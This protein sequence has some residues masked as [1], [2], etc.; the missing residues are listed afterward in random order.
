M[1]VIK[2]STVPNMLNAKIFEALINK[3]DVLVDNFR[4]ENRNIK[5]FVQTN[6]FF[7]YKLFI[8]WYY[9]G[10]WIVWIFLCAQSN[11]DDSYRRANVTVSMNQTVI[12][13]YIFIRYNHQFNSSNHN[14]RRYKLSRKQ[15]KWIHTHMNCIHNTCRFRFTYEMDIFTT[16]Q[17][18]Q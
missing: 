15:K 18:V 5:M 1:D 11:A 13:Q 2:T 8:N 7:A 12:G 6:A 14:F 17:L 9:S 3:L 10:C 16:F 4:F